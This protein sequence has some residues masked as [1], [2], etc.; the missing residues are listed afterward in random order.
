MVGKSQSACAK[1]G[2]LKLP[3]F[4]GLVTQGFCDVGCGE[5]GKIDPGTKKRTFKKDEIAV[6]HG[7]L[8]ESVKIFDYRI[9][10]LAKC[11][12]IYLPAP[13]HRSPIYHTQLPLWRLLY[14]RHPCQTPAP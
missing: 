13:E 12:A 5:P 4:G 10:M 9:G 7:D 3:C 1:S 8:E 11:I 14:N 6:Y 2:W